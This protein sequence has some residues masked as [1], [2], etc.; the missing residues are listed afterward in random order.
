MPG[1]LMKKTVVS[2]ADIKA[3]FEHN[4]A[5]FITPERR[6]I[7]QIPFPTEAVANE[8]YEKLIN[9]A[10]FMEIAKARGLDK[11]DVDL[12]LV[13]KA[14]V[15]DDAVADAVFALPVNEISKPIKGGLASVVAKVTRIEPEAVKTLED[16]RENIRNVLA[17]ER[18]TETILDA[19]DKI[20]DERAGGATLAEV[21]RKHDL[22]YTE[23]S[24]VDRRGRDTDGKTI[25]DLARQSAMMV[26][27]FQADVGLETDPVETSDRGYIWYEVLQVTPERL[28]PF[29]EVRDDVAGK[30]RETEARALLAN[31]G[32]ELVGKLRAGEQLAE[33]AGAFGIEVEQSKALK[34]SNRQEGLPSAAIQQAFA[35]KEGSF[36][37]ATAPDGKGRVVFQVLQATTPGAPDADTRRQLERMIIAQMGEDLI[38]QY[39]RALR[40]DVGVDINQSVFESATSG[41]AYSG[42]RGNS[43][44]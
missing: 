15:P 23:I 11:D 28:K 12:G 18:A 17:E 33:L 41:R 37:S 20:E 42:R 29:D 5:R 39:V 31:K 6:A 25:V 44:Y 36:G 38:M 8:A 3:Y 40:Q 24:A 30:W 34:R 7:L 26:S 22:N 14:G 27:I 10:D 2:D 19:Y 35:L 13:T 9:G 16:E 21:A 43:A 32:Q 4:K 1:A